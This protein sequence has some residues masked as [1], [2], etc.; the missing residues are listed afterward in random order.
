MVQVWK[1]T[2]RLEEKRLYRKEVSITEKAVPGA[3]KRKW[4][5]GFFLLFRFF[6]LTRC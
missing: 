3:T 6:E 1:G 2:D 5:S 4:D